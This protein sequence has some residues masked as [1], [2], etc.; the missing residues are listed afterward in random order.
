MELKLIGTAL[1]GADDEASHGAVAN[2]PLLVSLRLFELLAFQ[3]EKLPRSSEL[4]VQLSESQKLR[5]VEFIW[6]AEKL[7]FISF[8]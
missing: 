2:T 7:S 4:F 3:V 5:K 8:F 1:E 6:K